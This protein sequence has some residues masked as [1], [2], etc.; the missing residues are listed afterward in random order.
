[1]VTLELLVFLRRIRILLYDS[2]SSA[3]DIASNISMVNCNCFG[4]NRVSIF[5]ERLNIC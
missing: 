4:D 2:I 1:M 5:T 3:M